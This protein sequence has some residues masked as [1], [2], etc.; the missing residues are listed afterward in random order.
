M[1]LDLALL[2]EQ[3]RCLQ[4]GPFGLTYTTTSEVACHSNLLVG[5]PQKAQYEFNQGTYLKPYLASS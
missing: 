1:G 2:I 3:L 5:P 4:L